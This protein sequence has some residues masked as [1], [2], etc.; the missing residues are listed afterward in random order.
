MGGQPSS[1]GKPSV[2]GQ[3]FTRGKPTW[4]QHQQDWGKDAPT[5]PSIPTTNS[6]C[7]RLPYPG[8]GNPL[9][10]KPNPTGIP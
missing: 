7:P 4:F 2:V 1:R 6:M 10:D 8:V 5:S 3:L 9:W